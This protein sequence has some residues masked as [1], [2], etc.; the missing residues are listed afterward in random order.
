MLRAHRE[1]ARAAEEIRTIY[2]L[3]VSD[4]QFFKLQQF[5]VTNYGLV[6]Y[7][8]VIAVPKLLEKNG[9]SPYEYFALFIVAFVV[10]AAAWLLLGSL[11]Q[12]I[13]KGRKR[14]DEVKKHLTDEARAIVAFESAKD[15]ASLLWLFRA[16][17]GVGFLIVSWLLYK[18]ACAPE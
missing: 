12:A 9:L 8:A 17:L 16:V 18:M 13:E 3:V 14:L 5:R 4:V 15:K 1:K 6:L 7:A 11:A 10:L 2:G